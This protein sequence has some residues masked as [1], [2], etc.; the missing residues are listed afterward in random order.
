MG[1]QLAVSGF[2]KPLSRQRYPSALYPSIFPLDEQFGL[3]LRKCL[4]VG[5]QSGVADDNITYP[6]G[7]IV[8]WTRC[9]VNAIGRYEIDANLVSPVGIVR[10]RPSS[11]IGSAAKPKLIG[12]D[13]A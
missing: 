11:S 2:T 9:Q 3:P 1:L 7:C 13:T 4:D 10:G 8:G 5:S 6:I 12:E